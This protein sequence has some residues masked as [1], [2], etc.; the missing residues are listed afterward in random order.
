[1]ISDKNKSVP[2]SVYLATGE[3]EIL[4]ARYH[5]NAM[6][7]IE[8]LS[9]Q[10]RVQIG[11]DFLVLQG[12]EI[13]YLPPK[14]ICRMEAAEGT[15]RVRGLIFDADVLREN[16]YSFDTEILYMFYIQSKNHS[17]PFRPDHP[18][19]PVLSRGMRESYDE[20]LAKDVCYKMPIRAN[21]YLMMTALLRFYC[22]SRDES[23]RIVYH[24]VLRLRPVMDFIDGHYQ[25]KMRIE[26]LASMITVSADYFTK[27]FKESIGKTPVDYINGIRVN[28]ALYLLIYTDLSMQEISEQTGFC[29]ANYFHKIFKTYIDMSPLS[30]RK[31]ARGGKLLRDGET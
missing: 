20:F 18:N 29:N 1:M 13:L 4:G 2:I 23:D 6:E 14:I 24:N 11:T 5:E 22:G 17:T 19:Y 16:M 28:R 15:A 10:V 30:Y 3:E 26:Q 9:G 27:M 31:M 21:I 8:V 12:G 25:E 7:F